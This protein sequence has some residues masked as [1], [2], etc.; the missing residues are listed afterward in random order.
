M[1]SLPQFL[2]PEPLMK[3]TDVSQ[4]QGRGGR[5]PLEDMEK[6]SEIE[7]SRKQLKV[8]EKLPKNEKLCLSNGFDM[9]ESPPPKTENE[10]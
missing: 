7:D 5:M 10:V 6:P 1:N 8:E 3:T 4:H 9:F 2:E